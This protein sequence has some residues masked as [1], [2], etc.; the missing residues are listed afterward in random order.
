M[1][2]SKIESDKFRFTGWNIERCSDGWIR[3]SMSEYANSMEEVT[4]IRKGGRTERLNHEEMKVYRIL[5][6]H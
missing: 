1:T 3:V 2:L 5:Q 6:E 4:N